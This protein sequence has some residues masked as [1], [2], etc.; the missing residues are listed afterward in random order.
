M[1]SLEQTARLEAPFASILGLPVIPVFP[2]AC[3]SSLVLS[4]G[5]L[6]RWEGES[7]EESLEYFDLKK[8]KLQT[9]DEP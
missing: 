7:S 4:I 8:E 3:P 1:F 6:G 9:L 2:E 5:T